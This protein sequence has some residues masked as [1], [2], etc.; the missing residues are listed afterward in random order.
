MRRPSGEPRRRP[1][2][3]L[4][5][6]FNTSPPPHRYFNSIQSDCFNAIMHSDISMVVAA[7]TG[8]GKTVLLELAILR[9][10]TRYI[11]PAGHFQHQKGILYQ[12]F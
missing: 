1:Y 12:N 11:T 5:A 4:S 7:P 6:P 2:A 8:A 9:L 10:L 3:A